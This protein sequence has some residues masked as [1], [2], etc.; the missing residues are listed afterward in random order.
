MRKL[1]LLL[2][3]LVLSLAINAAVI[4]INTETADALRLALN[5]AAD[6]DI[7]E[8]A[9]G[10]YVESNENYIAF[11]GKAVTVRAAEGAEVILQPKVPITISEGGCAHFQ[12]IKI[13]ASRL[14]ELADW[15][16]HVIYSTDA[17]VD[18]RIILEG[19]EI[20]GFALNKSLISC[21]ASAALDALT[22]NNCYFHNINKSCVFI[23]NTTN[24]INIS[25][26]NST[27]ANITTDAGS[28]YAGVIDS[29]A[30]SGSFLVDHCTFYDV[31]VINTDYAAIGNKNNTPS[32]SV[33][34]NCIFAMPS[35][36]DGVRAIRNIAQANNCLTYNYIYDSKWG[37]HSSV[38]KNNCIQKKDPL[39]VDAANANFKLHLGSPAIGAATD[40][41]DLGDPRW[42]KVAI[43]STDFTDPLALI[44]A[45]AVLANHIELT[46]NWY[47]K[48]KN[49]DKEEHAAEYGTATW[50]FNTTKAS[51]VQVTINM[52]PASDASGHN[53]HVEIFDSNNASKGALEEGEWCNNVDD[54]LLSGMIFLPEAGTYTVVLSNN[55]EWSEAVAKGITLSYIAGGDVVEIPNTLTANDAWFTSKGTRADG[56]ISFSTYKEQW[57]KWNAT[58]PGSLAYAYDV[59][60]N[61]YSPNEYG[62]RF[63]VKFYENEN[64]EPVYTLT[65][66]SW[67]KSYGTPLAIP[68]GKVTLDPAKNYIVEVTNAENGAQPKIVSVSFA[69]SGGNVQN[70]PATTNIED[71]WFSPNGTR[72]DGKIDF[73]DG[74]IQDGWVKWN[75]AFAESGSYKATVKVN[76]NSG[77]N[78]TVKLYRDKN[79]ENPITFANGLQ[80]S[81]KG[82]PID[83][84]I[85][86]QVIEAGSYIM[87]VVNSLT[88]SDAE[89]ISVEFIYSGGAT[90]NIPNAAIPLNEAI[91]NN[92]AT[93]D[94]EGIHFGM[95]DRY[96]EWNVAAAAGLY[97]FTF[98]VVGTNFGKYQLT[99]IDSESNTIYD[100]YK[101]QSGSGSVSH[102]SIYLDGNYT[103]RVANTNSGADGYITSIAATAEENV[104]ILDENTVDDGSIAAAAGNTYKFL[105][106]RSF[107]A[108]R[109]YTI[110]IP[111]GSWDDELNLAFGADYELW[112]MSSATQSGDEISLNFEQCNTESFHAGWPYLIKPSIDVQ[113][114]VFYNLKT[115]QNSTYNNV[116]SFD[117]ADFVGSFYKTEI[118]AGESNLYLQNNNLYY[119]PTN[120]TPMKGTRAWIRLKQQSGQQAPARAR[121]VLQDKV[122]TGIDLVQPVDNKAV[123]T[124]ENGQF[125]IIKNGIRYNA[126]G[127]M[128]K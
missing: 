101:G 45:D 59:A 38:A 100:E 50:I 128:I 95:A 41:S 69:Y 83:L 52:D 27:F 74:T 20:Y 13:D 54:K 114:P 71:A 39:F 127:T 119:S 70:M 124:I 36:V 5:S 85:N 46:E 28:Y 117:A 62:H 53:Y 47:L 81:Q 103:I 18:N 89:L 88:N 108:G 118:P 10:T 63:S 116:Q 87:E 14:T 48:S 61:I 55:Q 94:N 3:A 65:E 12:N 16:E 104:F 82:S 96:A 125:V 19:C 11:T 22:I 40:G 122:A 64:E 24:A 21:S 17:A 78:Y 25:I 97:T 76:T 31:Q 8:M 30:T 121:I 34:S 33:V 86:A 57:V 112:K 9:A 90:V 35:S 126:M 44:G 91:L 26:T 37:I 98:N 23:E 120:A 115:I 123:K 84:E 75:V 32:G 107:T 51:A 99:I 110:C 77:H 2:P 79:D 42:S 93:R 102:S 60:L 4:N 49:E 58:I 56:M 68:M 67:N 109:Y 80:Y 73:P 106:K 92:G 7:I 72:A 113:N 111:V 105:L 29:R 66:S 43:P 6:G 15:Y 1:F